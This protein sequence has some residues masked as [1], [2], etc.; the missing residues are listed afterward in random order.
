MLLRFQTLFNLF[1][2]RLNPYLVKPFMHLFEFYS[3]SYLSITLQFPFIIA[4]QITKPFFNRTIIIHIQLEFHPGVA[5]LSICIKHCTGT[6][7][8][9]R[10]VY[11]NN[12]KTIPVLSSKM[13]PSIR[14][15]K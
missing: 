2:F 15:L 7:N 14:R 1:N 5:L 9:I 8:I 6:D 4:K 10:W 12:N 11:S 13:K 3:C